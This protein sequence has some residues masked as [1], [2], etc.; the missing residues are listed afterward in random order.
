[1]SGLSKLGT[2]AESEWVARLPK[3]ASKRLE[4]TFEKVHFDGLLNVTLF[5]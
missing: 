1:M 2:K 5:D 4:L 3:A